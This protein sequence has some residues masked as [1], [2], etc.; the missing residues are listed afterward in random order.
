MSYQLLTIQLN[1]ILWYNNGRADMWKRR[2]TA[3]I[4]ARLDS[5]KYSTT[6]GQQSNGNVMNVLI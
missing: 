2:D 3:E 1:E 6:P 4:Y 5:S